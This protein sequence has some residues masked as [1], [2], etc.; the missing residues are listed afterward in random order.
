MAALS[1]ERLAAI[2]FDVRQYIEREHP[3]QIRTQALAQRFGLGTRE[4]GQAL[5]HLGWS[6]IRTYAGQKEAKVWIPPIDTTL[7]STKLRDLLRKGAFTFDQLADRLGTTQRTIVSMCDQLRREGYLVHEFGGHVE[8]SKQ[9]GPSESTEAHILKSDKNGYTKF[10]YVSDNHLCSK[11]ARED[12]LADLYDW[13]AGEGCSTVFN[14]GN[15][16]DG[17]AR[18]NKHDIFVHGMENQVNYFVEKYPQRK[19]VVTKFIS[20]DDHEGWYC[21]E[22]GVEIFTPHGWRVLDTLPE[23]VE[24]ATMTTA[25]EFQWQVPTKVI[26]KKHTGDL[27]RFKHRS[28]DVAVTPDHRFETLV[29]ASMH[30]TPAMQVMPAEE[31]ERLFKPRCFGIPRAARVWGGVNPGTVTVPRWESRRYKEDKRTHHFEKLDALDAAELMAWYATEGSAD[32]T[33]VGIAQ[34]TTA[35][36]ANCSRIAHLLDRIGAKYGQDDSKFRVC[37]PELANWLIEQCGRYSENKRLPRWVLDLPTHGLQ[38]VLEALVLGDGSFRGEGARF[39]SKSKQLLANVTEIA[40]KLGYGVT[41]YPSKNCQ[42]LSISMRHVDAF[43]FKKPVREAYSGLVHCVSV[44]NQRIYVRKNGKSFWSM[45]CQREGI[46]IGDFTESKA[47]AAGRSDL[48]HLGFLESFVTLE[49]CGNDTATQ[50]LL[51]HPGGGSAYATSYAPQKYVEALSGGEKPAM[52]LFGH[53]HKIFDLLIRNVI[54]LGGG[55][56]KDLDPFGRKM[57]LAYHLGGLIVETW[58]DE[59]GAIS[60]WRVEKRQF[61]DRGYYNDQWSYTGQPKRRAV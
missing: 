28:M 5:T 12:C 53:W 31:I 3:A 18:F 33:T 13:F 27:L 4:I 40:Q 20:G 41:E 45:N 52:I 51:V 23:Q 17:E 15:W 24:V 1:P 55:C 50:I 57:K 49:N 32:A 7:D 44:P 11:Y 58:Q 2:A 8:I 6:R 26:H 35:N 22:S 54:C 29:K 14:T 25:G 21:F 56:T 61:F 42:C 10:G 43:L 9:P 19:G 46:D 39:Y 16:I 60:R 38:R 36:P 48:L 37:S 34:D 47:R 30:A 59:N